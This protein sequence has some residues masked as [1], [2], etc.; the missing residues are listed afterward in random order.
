MRS[1]TPR[2]LA[3]SSTENPCLRKARARQCGLGRPPLASGVHPALLGDRNIGGLTLLVGKI[4]LVAR[5][6]KPHRHEP[7]GYTGNGG[8][9]ISWGSPK[10]TAL[11]LKASMA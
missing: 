8:S 3:I 2:A 9:V 11:A 4:A 10:S 5:W 6:I 7:P 1:C